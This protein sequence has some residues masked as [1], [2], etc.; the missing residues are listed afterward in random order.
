[1]TRPTNR[2][3]T[4]TAWKL[5]RLVSAR[6]IDLLRSLSEFRLLTTRH[7]QEL[8]FA[9][10]ASPGATKRAANR[11]LSKLHDLKLVQPTRGV[12]GGLGGGETPFVWRLG[13]A[14]DRLIRHLDHQSGKPRFHPLDAS[15][16]FFEH[17]LAISDAVVRLVRASREGRFELLEL[18]GEPRNWRSYP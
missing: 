5:E 18:R 11:A 7:L 1:M 15:H 17:T 2:S 16:V 13:D 10:H 3:G 9:S 8:H 14:G 12:R 4:L 6:D